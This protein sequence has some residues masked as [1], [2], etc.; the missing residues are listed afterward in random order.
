MDKISERI[1]GAAAGI[2]IRPVDP[3]MGAEVLGADLSQP[4]GEADLRRYQ[5]ALHTHKVLVYRDQDLTKEQLIAFSRRWGPLGEHIMPGAASDD[6]EEFNVHVERRAGRQAQRQA[7]RP[8]GEALAY[9]PVV[10]A[11]AGDDDDALRRRGAERSAATRC[12]PTRRW[13]TMRCRRR[14]ATG[15]TSS[16]RSTR[17]SIRGATEAWRWPR[18]TS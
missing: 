17:S 14:R 12:S 10:H 7:S 9:R 4:L 5:D 13:P 8:D 18:S 1:A 6:Y 16:T 11:A 3:V 2:V 15:S